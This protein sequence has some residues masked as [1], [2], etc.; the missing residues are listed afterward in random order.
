MI[1]KEWCF[2]KWM[3]VCIPF[4]FRKLISKFNFFFP[5][6]SPT[7]KKESEKKLLRDTEREKQF[8]IFFASVVKLA[9]VGTKDDGEDGDIINIAGSLFV[10]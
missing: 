2:K 3:A 6:L 8:F 5:F 1:E 9:V 4:I 7:P 10:V